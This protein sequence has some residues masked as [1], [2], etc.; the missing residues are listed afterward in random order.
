MLACIRK[1]VKNL[2]TERAFLFQCLILPINYNLLLILFALAGSNAPT[3]VVL[4]EQGPYAQAMVQA[5]ASAHSFSLSETTERQ[6][7]ELMQ[8]GEIVAIVT[9]PADF[10]SRVAL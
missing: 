5:L 10:D 1:D 2:L 4:Q 7:E 6:A 3:A 8:Q 9:I